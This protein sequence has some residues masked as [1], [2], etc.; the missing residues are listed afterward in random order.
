MTNFIFKQLINGEWVDAANGKTW[1]LLNPATEESR[2]D[3]LVKA[4]DWVKANHD[5]LARL[6]TEECG[7]PF[8][9][10]KA[11]W[12][13]AINLFLWYAEECKRVYGRTIPARVQGRRISVMYQ[14][15]GVVGTISAW[16][17]PVY[18]HIRQWAA[19]LAAGCTVV[20]RP[21]EFT[22]RSAMLTAQALHD[23]GAP[24][25][26]I[27]LINGDADSMGKAMLKDPRCRKVCFTGSTRVG[28]LLMDGASETVT[29]LAL[30]LGGN[31]P[32]IIFPD[33]KSVPATAKA[34]AQWK[35]RNAGQVCISPQRFYVHSQIAEEFIETAANVTKAMKLGSGLE[36]TTDVGPMINANQRVRVE[37]L[38]AD[39]V[40]KKFLDQCCLSCRSPIPRKCWRWRTR[41]SSDCRRMCIP[42][43]SKQQSICTKNWNTAW[44]RSMTGSRRQQKHRSAAG[45]RAVSGANVGAKESKSS[46]RPRRCTLVG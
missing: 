7:K 6:T 18:N 23:S 26:T 42:M 31:A 43:T 13:A 4:A 16:N 40:T 15:I 46:L 5:D 30:E 39:A 44:S 34:A 22:P 38:V 19:A 1:N 12:Q 35:Y 33:M 36:N 2:G 10:A 9:E 24:A 41:Q 14:P 45:S 27:N 25:G 21:S 11:E 17:F 37:S 8:R 20:G 28:K 29:K 3:V 32:V